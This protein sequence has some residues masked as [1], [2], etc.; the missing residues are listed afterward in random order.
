VVQLLGRLRHSGRA[1]STATDLARVESRGTRRHEESG[2]EMGS[3]RC[4]ARSG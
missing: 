3:L 4:G 2:T 1:R